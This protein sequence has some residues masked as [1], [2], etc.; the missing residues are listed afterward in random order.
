MRADMPKVLVER[1]RLGAR[2]RFGSRRCKYDAKTRCREGEEAPPK[3]MPMRF[4]GSRGLNENL[5][6][7]RRFLMKQRG[8]PWDE[9]YSEIRAR[10]APRSAVDMHVMQHLWAFV[11]FARR[12]ATGEEVLVDHYGR[13]RA[14]LT[15]DAGDGACST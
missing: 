5:E 2:F 15:P 7:L 10:L 1:P 12:N 11:L 6:P 8:R 13:A 14:T 9:V 4:A 3:S